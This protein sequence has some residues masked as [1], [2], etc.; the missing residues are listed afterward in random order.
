MARDGEPRALG[1]GDRR[2]LLALARRALEVYLR[3]SRIPQEPDDEAAFQEPRSV[4]VT[5]KC[6]R[7][8]RGCIGVL[9]GGSS[10]GE[11]VQ[12]C[13]VSAANDPRFPPLLSDELAATRIEI[14]VLGMPR[15]I[16]GPED[17]TVG[18]DGLIVSRGMRKGLLLPQVAVEQ[19]W[20]AGRFVE[21]TCVKAGLPRDAWKTGATLEAFTADVFGE[22]D[23]ERDAI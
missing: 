14:S 21:E 23:P 13:A 4:F 12:H 7:K 10:L 1:E 11:N 9:S 5:L 3:E 2:A 15:A 16:G 22:D 8:L 20:D 17:V 19:R 6:H 18:K